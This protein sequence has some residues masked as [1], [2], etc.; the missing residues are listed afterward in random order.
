MRQRFYER[1]VDGE[2]RVKEVSHLE[3]VRLSHEPEEFAIAVEDP[4]IC[5]PHEPQLRL[6]E[7]VEQQIVQ[8]T[9]MVLVRQLYGVI[10]SPLHV[11]YDHRTAV[12][13]SLHHRTLA[14]LLKPDHP[15]SPLST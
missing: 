14:Q 15:D 7:A 3:T 1:G 2:V 4:T 12:L 6:I 5:V 9:R 10:P 13:N 8:V 11:D